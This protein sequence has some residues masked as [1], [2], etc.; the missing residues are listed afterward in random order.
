MP[1]GH[2]RLR[3][4]TP[5]LRRAGTNDKNHY[6]EQI[7]RMMPNGSSFAE[8]AVSVRQSFRLIRAIRFY[9]IGNGREQNG[10]EQ[11]MDFRRTERGR[12]S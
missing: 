6:E 3:A 12:A 9:F 10:G 11:N 7:T 5:A 2:T 4:E 1:K 8:F